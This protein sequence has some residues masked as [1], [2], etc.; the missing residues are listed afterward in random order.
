MK[1]CFPVQQ[2]NGIESTVFGHFGSAP[3]FVVVDS[4]TNDVT[5]IHNRDQ[6]HTHGACNPIKALDNN[7][8]DA[9]VVGGI[10][11]GALTRL[12]QSGIKVYRA[13][14]ET[15]GENI[16]LFATSNLPELTVQGCC[17]GHSTDGACA[18]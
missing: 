10:G 1:L 2:D 5:T 12:N 9:V 6:H 18:H 13:Q 8:V 11:A 16:V 4:E 14:S 3:A 7:K 15:I 17:G